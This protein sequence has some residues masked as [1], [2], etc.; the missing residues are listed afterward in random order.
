MEYVFSKAL[1]PLRQ[2]AV[3]EISYCKWKWQSL[4]PQSVLVRLYVFTI[5]VNDL[6]CVMIESATDSVIEF[7][8]SS[9]LWQSLLLVKL[10]TFVMDGNEQ[11]VADSVTESCV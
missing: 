1:R 5:N 3:I 11:F 10:Q 4:E 6:V 2:M 9:R 8:F 7:V